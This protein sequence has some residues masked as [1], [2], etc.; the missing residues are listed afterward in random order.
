M[1]LVQLLVQVVSVVVYQ[2]KF[3]RIYVVVIIAEGLHSKGDMSY[4]I[5]ILRSSEFDRLPYSRVRE[6]FGVTSPD[7][8]TIYVRNTNIHDFNKMLVSHELDHLT[9]EVPTDVGPD[10]ERYFLGSILPFLG[11]LFTKALPAIGGGIANL[12]RSAVSGIGNVASRVGSGASSLLSG[13]KS[14]VMNLF[15]GGGQQTANTLGYGN[16]VSPIAMGV[17]KGM[18]NAAGGFS[19]LMKGTELSQFVSPIRNM[20]GGLAS[21]AVSGLQKTLGSTSTGS[22]TQEEETGEGKNFLDMFK[23]PQT[24]LGAGMIG[25]SLFKK[26]PQVGQLPESLQQAQGMSS[27]TSDPRSAFARD[28][29]SGMIGESFDP[30]TDPEIQAYNRQLDLE[31]KQAID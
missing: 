19:P 11:S 20:G 28:Q 17:R 26:P 22:G 16:S 14:G 10:G 23:N 7:K 4:S 25:A 27:I 21:G 12:G 8:S 2:R 15:G 24:A 18:T 9:E 3:L 29:L 1:Y 6:A 30:L 31:K 13:A 5:K